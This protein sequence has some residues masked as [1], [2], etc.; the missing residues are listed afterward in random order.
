M[1]DLAIEVAVE[2]YTYWRDVEKMTIYEMIHAIGNGSGP[3]NISGD[4]IIYWLAQIWD[5][6]IG[7]SEEPP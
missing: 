1:S 5:S 7:R 4:G 2:Q 6:Q 3:E